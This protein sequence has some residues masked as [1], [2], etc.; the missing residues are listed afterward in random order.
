MKVYLAPLATILDRIKLEQQT[1]IPP[2][3]QE[4]VE[5]PVPLAKPLH[6][7]AGRPMYP[8]EKGLAV[9]DLFEYNVF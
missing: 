2:H 4:G 3:N 5:C 1:P 8:H 7:A 9:I 6:R